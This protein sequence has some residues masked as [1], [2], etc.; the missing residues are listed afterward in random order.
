MMR[1]ADQNHLHVGDGTIIT[2]QEHDHMSVP[3][4]Y[5]VCNMLR[6]FNCCPS[7]CLFVII[8]GAVIHKIPITIRLLRQLIEN[9]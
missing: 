7:N 6:E 5:I 9:E 4:L 2:M 3:I 1:S 8:I